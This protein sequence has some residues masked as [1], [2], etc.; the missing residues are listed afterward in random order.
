MGELIRTLE[1]RGYV[2]RTADPDDG[3]ARLVRLTA[4]GRQMVRTALAHIAA[5]ERDWLGHLN[6][7]DSAGSLRDALERAV[8]RASSTGDGEGHAGRSRDDG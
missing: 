7:V 2:E 1:A 5:I 8:T 6:I 4:K 3:R